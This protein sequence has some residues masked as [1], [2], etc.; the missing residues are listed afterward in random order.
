MYGGEGRC[1]QECG[2]DCTEEK[3]VK[4]GGT[5]LREDT[6]LIKAGGQQEEGVGG[7]YNIA[8]WGEDPVRMCVRMFLE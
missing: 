2:L 3:G 1:V 7:M 8:T 5:R 6:W 4:R